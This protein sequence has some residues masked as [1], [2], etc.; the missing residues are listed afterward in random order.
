M[1]EVGPE[2]VW[3]MREIGIDVSR[4]VSKQ[5]TDDLR[6]RANLLVYLAAPE[7]MPSYMQKHKAL[8]SYPVPDPSDMTHSAHIEMRERVKEVVYR[9]IEEVDGR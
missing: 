2:V 3:V 5:L 1:E 8:L 4:A 7:D 6:R 9:V